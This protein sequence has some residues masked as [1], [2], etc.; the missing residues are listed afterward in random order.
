MEILNETSLPAREAFTNQLNGSECSPADYAHAQNV[1]NTFELQNLKQY[2][3][4]YLFADVCQLTDVF[5]DYRK[6]CSEAYKLDPAYFLSAPQLSFNALLRFIKRPIELISDAEMYRMIQ[7]SIRSGICRASVR[8]AS[9]NNKYIGSL[10]RP[11]EESLYILYIDATNLYGYAKSQALPN[12][13]FTWLS[14]E[15]CRAADLALTGNQESRDAFF[16]IDPGMLGPY[17]ILEVDLIYP[18]EIHDR[19]DDY[20]MAPQLMNVRAEMLSETHHRLL[21]NYFNGVAP[22][23]K[24]LICSFLPCLKYT[25]FGQNLQFYLSRGMKLTKVHRGIKFTGLAYLAG[26]IKHNTEMRQ[27]NRGDETKKNFYKLMNNPPYGKT[28]ENVA[29]RSDIRLIVDELKVVKLSEKPNC[30]D[31]RMFA[32][33]QFGVEMRKTK[34]LI[35]KP[36]HVCRHDFIVGI[37]I[38]LAT[39]Q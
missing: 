3:E 10:Y 9:A 26:Y 39:K 31:F 1:W 8:Y 38:L 34:S 17:Y 4:L 5:Q 19:D 22:G 37:S 35:N 36:F 11:D 25:V 29:K 13:H 32:S 30:I 14:E 27:A 28:I 6:T 15:E 33:N 23:S 2:L 21:V 12:I 20:P 7:T 24:K 16:K 18:P